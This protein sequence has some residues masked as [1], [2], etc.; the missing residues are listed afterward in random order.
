MTLHISPTLE[1]P[2][3]AAT[4]TRGI[5]AKKGSGKSNAA[6][7]LAEELHDAGVAWV[8]IDPKGDWYGV[9]SSSDGTKPG[10]P[11]YVFGGK[12]GDAPLEATAGALMADLILGDEDRGY[13]TC[14]LD[15]SQFT[16]SDQRRFLL[17]FG[18]RLYRQKDEEGVLH[19]FLEE[20]HE[21]L[22]QQVP[23]ESTQLVST[24]QRIVKLGRTKGLG[25]TLVSQRSA[26]LN[27]DVLTQVDE[28]VVLRTM[29][30]Q[31][32][33][34]VKAWLDV[35]VGVTEVINTLHELAKGEAWLWAPDR[36]DAPVR[37]QFRRRRTFDSGATPEVGKVRRAPATLA[38]VD[39]A[40]IKE[41]M[42]ET[43]EQAKAND[44]KELRRRIATLERQLAERPAETVEVE[45][46][47]EVEVVREIVPGELI[48]SVNQ[49]R[50]ALLDFAQ[51]ATTLSAEMQAAEERALE[52]NDR[53][54]RAE[55]K[56][57]TPPANRHDRGDIPASARPARS[58]TP[59]IDGDVHLK[60]GARRILE[61]L[62]R[63]HPMKVT[64]SQVGTLTGFKVTGGTFQTY[65][66]VLKRAGY[67]DEHG[68]EISVTDGGLAV[69]GVEHHEPLTTAEVIETWR[70]AL[71][72]GARQ[73]LDV[74]ID[75]YPHG[76]TRDELADAVGMTPT[77]G[78]F[79]TYL[80]TLRRNGLVD[81]GA[82]VR[83][84]ETLFLGGSP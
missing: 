18:E 1:L 64:R 9:R 74:L 83:A 33:A 5:L 42:A 8:A 23:R 19:L 68:G 25:I 12:H 40:V 43:I 75:R 60:A 71:K 24:W 2:V 76:L 34:V 52:R 70:R 37:F 80:S 77:G 31:D 21:Y 63:H 66:S 54:G 82:D 36:F 16:I 47:V 20:A 59:V 13:L 26:A 41:Q 67:I 27:K 15:V 44:P 73:M 79:Q 50:V 58:S 57:P 69:A 72:A 45:R 10:L 56:A 22:P 46:V 78:T 53:S 39:L 35:H 4:D 6:V 51:R 30:P 17:A 65:W 49:A 7:V 48:S 11:V 29:S 28:L 3:D 61:V 81:V 14:V 38:D 55:R 62:A 32:R 84:S